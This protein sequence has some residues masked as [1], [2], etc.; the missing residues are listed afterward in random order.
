MWSGR[1]ADMNEARFGRGDLEQHLADLARGRMLGGDLLVV[2][3]ARALV[4]GGHA[5]VHPVGGIKDFSGLGQVLGR[6]DAGNLEN[7]GLGDSRSELVTE[8]GAERVA[9]VA[10]PGL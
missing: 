9:P 2:L 10:L 8:V 6:E 7:H 5:A 3:H 4:P 1:A